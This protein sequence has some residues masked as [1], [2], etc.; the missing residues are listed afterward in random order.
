LMAAQRANR[1]IGIQIPQTNGLIHAARSEKR[2]IRVKADTDNPMS[3]IRQDGK[4]S[5]AL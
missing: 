2:A 5:A 1:L 4:F 3:V